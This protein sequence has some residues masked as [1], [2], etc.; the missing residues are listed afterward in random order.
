MSNLTLLVCK[1]DRWEK[2]GEEG[3]EG[4]KDGEREGRREKKGKDRMKEGRKKRE[5][6]RNGGKEIEKEER[7]L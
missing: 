5:E 7:K 6:W 3:I 4:R 2:E 1:L